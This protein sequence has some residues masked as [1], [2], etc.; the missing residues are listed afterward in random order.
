MAHRL[1]IARS[2]QAIGFDLSRPQL[3][4]TPFMLA[5]PP[6]RVRYYIGGPG[7][8]VNLHGSGY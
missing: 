5:V 3:N 4:A 8:F 1:A 2:Y 6:L 7:Y